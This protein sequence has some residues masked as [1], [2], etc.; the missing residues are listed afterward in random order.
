ML[1]LV[2]LAARVYPDGREEL[3]SGVDF[4]GTPLNALRHIIAVG[5]RRVLDNSFCG[6]ESG[7][8]PVS[9]ISPAILIAHL[10]LQAKEDNPFTPPC[11]E[12]PF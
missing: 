8:L 5:R 1:E 2:D 4:V 6:A 9:T 7:W 3:V 12:R 10:E 11:Y